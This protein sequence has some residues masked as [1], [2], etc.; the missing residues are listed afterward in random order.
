DRVPSGTL[1][2][3]GVGALLIFFL[4]SM[5]AVLYL[6]ARQAE[7]GP[8]AV[9]A[10]I[11]QNKIGLVEQQIFD[12]SLRGERAEARARERLGSFGWVDRKAGLAHIPIDEAM[13]LVGQGVRAGPVS[14]APPPGGQP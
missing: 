12:L 6:R 3:V 14:G 11:G 1:V 9:P 5:A 4:G 8:V 2:L 7:R 13:R 10:E